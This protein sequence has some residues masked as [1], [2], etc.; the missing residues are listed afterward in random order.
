MTQAQLDRS[1]A[2]ATGE[3]RR[4]VRMRGFSLADPLVAA[5]DP[6]PYVP[7]FTVDEPYLDWDDVAGE[8]YAELAVH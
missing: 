7:Q 1:V 5:F 6:E 4:T 2:A 8:R 3:S